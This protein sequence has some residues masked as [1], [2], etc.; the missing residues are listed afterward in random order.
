MVFGS[1]SEMSLLEVLKF[2][3]E[4]ELTGVLKFNIAHSLGQIEVQDG[5]LMSA[6]FQNMTGMDVLWKINNTENG[7]FEFHKDTQ[8]KGD[9]LENYPTPKLLKMLETSRE[10]Y[11][12]Q[13]SFSQKHFKVNPDSIP[14]INPDKEISSLNANNRILKILLLANGLNSI[15]DIAYRNKLNTLSVC[16]I[17]ERLVEYH[18]IELIEPLK[19]AEIEETSLPPS[20]PKEDP[21]IAP[22]YYRGRKI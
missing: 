4:S 15:K 11:K 17:F 21:I 10:N 18:Y 1:F 8:I 7:N 16:K 20:T 3:N 2:L 12:S 19:Q 6:N 22:R 9:N 13:G 14:I 5:L